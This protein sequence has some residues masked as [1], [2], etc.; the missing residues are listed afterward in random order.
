MDHFLIC[1][2]SRCR[3]VVDTLI[4]GKTPGNGRFVLEKCPECGSA[5]SANCP[6]S[7]RPLVVQWLNALPHCLC[8]NRRL[9][10][11]AAAAA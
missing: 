3:L 1:E 7:G 9:A 11:T 10:A 5:W 6:F 8:C 4:E 2:N